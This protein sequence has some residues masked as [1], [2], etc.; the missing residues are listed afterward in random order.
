MA[1][2]PRCPGTTRRRPTGGAAGGSPESSG[3]SLQAANDFFANFSFRNLTQ[4]ATFNI[5]LV[6]RAGQEANASG[7]VEPDSPMSPLPRPHSPP[8]VCSSPALPPNAP[9]S[10]AP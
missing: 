8:S 2:M 10:F 7:V 1:A 3:W 9:T 6:L 4:L 5:D